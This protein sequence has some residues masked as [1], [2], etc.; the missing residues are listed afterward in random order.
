M[1]L[2]TL[3]RTDT[4][5]LAFMVA[6]LEHMPANLASIDYRVYLD[7]AMDAWNDRLDSIARKEV[8]PSLEGGRFADAQH[9]RGVR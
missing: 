5:R 6:H 3:N 9:P 2:N 1:T 8:R 7:T 4:D